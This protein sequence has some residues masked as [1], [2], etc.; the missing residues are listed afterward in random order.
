M[1]SF[2]DFNQ[3]LKAKFEMLPYKRRLLY[4]F[5]NVYLYFEACRHRKKHTTIWTK[6]IF[7]LL[8]YNI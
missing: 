2:L 8:K 7:I 6:S 1:P 5:D 4:Y 3:F